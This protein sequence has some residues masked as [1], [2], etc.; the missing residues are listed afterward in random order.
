MDFTKKFKMPY[1]VDSKYETPSAYFSMEF[2][3]DQ[4]LK[5]YSGGL[6]FLAGSHMRSAYDLKQNLIGIGILWKYGYYDQVRKGDKSMAVLFQEKLYSFLEDTGIVFDLLVHG[7]FVKVKAFYLDP[8]TF[9]TVP[10]FFLSTDLPENDYLSQTISHRLYDA[11]NITRIAQSIL[12]GFGGA[13]LLEILGRETNIYHINEAHA[14]PVAFYLYEKYQNLE[15][16]KKHFVFTTHTPEEAGNEIHDVSLLSKMSY[17]G[18]KTTIEEMRKITGVVTENFNTSLVALRLAKIANGVSK[19]HGEVSNEMWGSYPNICSITSVTNAQ[20]K[21][22]WADSIMD[23]CFKNKDVDGIRERKRVLKKRF[24]E[25]VADQSGKLMDPDVLTLVWARRFAGYKRADLIT[26]DLERFESIINNK[27]RP[28]QIIWAGKPYPM[29]YSAIGTFDNLVHLNKS[30]MNTAILVGY[31][32]YLSRMCK[33]GSDVWLNNPRI[34][35]E[36]SGTSGMTAAM[37]G[38]VNFST[39]D[40]WI[41]EFAKDNENSFV[42]PKVSPRLPVNEQ[43]RLDVENLYEILENKIIPTYYERP[44]QWVEIVM[45]S[46]RDVVPFFD[47]D[48][49]ADQ[50]YVDLYDYSHAEVLNEA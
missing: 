19:K 43:D 26:A 32:L 15:E 38:S 34:P 11:N 45:N 2:A 4:P 30:Y 1:E 42:I 46:M 10:M 28:V 12:L 37:N 44:E 33:V 39:Q 50:Y 13:K 36:A 35:R 8:K 31:E 25:I 18:E 22:Y 40:G 29:D 6:G 20:N 14:L 5:T 41:L 21:K 49:M 3:I 17:F 47:A 23:E 9:G 16:V 7:H 24:F 27:D 48:R